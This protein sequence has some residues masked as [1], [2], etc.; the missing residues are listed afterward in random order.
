AVELTAGWL[1]EAGLAVARDAAGNLYGRRSGSQPELPE[2]WT[3]SHFATVP[4]GGRCDGA[5]GVGGAIEAVGSLTPGRRTVAAVAFRDEEG[6]RFGGGCFG[7]RALC[8]RLDQG[9][10][11]KRD[12]DG[13]S[14]AEALA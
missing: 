11:E 8:G 10:L 2:V 14:V 13:V 9:E 12:A 6:V 5:L 4:N 7:S 1:A 3:G